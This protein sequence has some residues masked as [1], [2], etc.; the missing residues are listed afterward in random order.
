MPTCITLTL[1]E[2]EWTCAHTRAPRQNYQSQNKKLMHEKKKERN[3]PNQKPPPA[4]I[5]ISRKDSK[6]DGVGW[7]QVCSQWSEWEK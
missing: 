7:E 3:N 6:W 1:T 4:G 2:E 5:R